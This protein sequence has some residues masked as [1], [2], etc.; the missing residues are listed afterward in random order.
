VRPMQTRYTLAGIHIYNGSG[1]VIERVAVR[2]WPSDGI[3]LQTGKA[4]RVSKCI[5][6][7]CLGNGLHPGTGLSQGTFEENQVVENGAGMYFCWHNHR[8]VVQKNQFLRNREGGITG[9]GNPGD[10]ENVIEEN[11]IA[12]NGGPGIEI[13]G[14]MRSGNVIRRNV[15]ENNSQARPG[16]HPGIA[17]YASLEDARDYTIRG[18][19]IRDTQKSPTQ[20]IGVEEKDGSYRGKP[21]YADENLIRDNVFSGHKTADIVLAGAATRCEKNGEALVQRGPATE[22]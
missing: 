22:Q 16:K 19:S 18:N 15:V 8:H 3:S 13:N 7:G 5:I 2:D 14:G 1:V 20:F 11:L 12:D 6:T 10:R 21:T 4:C 17:L 9:L